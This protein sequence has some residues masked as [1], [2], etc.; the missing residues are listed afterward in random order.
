MLEISADAD[1]VIAITILDR[2][3]GRDRACGQARPDRIRVGRTVSECM[4]QR[5]STTETL[6]VD[7]IDHDRE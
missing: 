7:R 4:R 5:Y 6:P 1:A 3:D 2:H